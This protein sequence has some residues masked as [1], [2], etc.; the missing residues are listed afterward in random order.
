MSHKIPTDCF[1]CERGRSLFMPVHGRHDA[2]CTQRRLRTPPGPPLDRL[3]RQ[4]VVQDP[5]HPIP[6]SVC[7]SVF[8][9]LVSLSLP[10]SVCPFG[11]LISS[12]SKCSRTRSKF[13]RRG[14]HSTQSIQ[15][16]Q[17]KEKK[18]EGERV[19]PKSSQS[20]TAFMALR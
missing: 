19:K 17:D 12:A 2:E 14:T 11:P 15:Q 6:P 4:T 3:H 18:R 8:P 16:R 10:L 9:M 5:I 13:Y 7:A 20:V 1:M